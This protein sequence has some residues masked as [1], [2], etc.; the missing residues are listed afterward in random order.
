M[1][2]LTTPR[3]E[4]EQLWKDRRENLGFTLGFAF[5]VDF[6]YEGAEWIATHPQGGMMTP[7][8]VEITQFVYIAFAVGSAWAALHFAREYWRTRCA[9]EA[10][11]EKERKER[12]NGNKG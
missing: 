9:C 12:R 8:M 3:S 1:G 5:G 10:L 4:K 11:A 2:I 6:F 7:F